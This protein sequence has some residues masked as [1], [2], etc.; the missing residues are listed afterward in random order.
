[1]SRAAP[2][3]LNR[4]TKLIQEP[5]EFRDAVTGIELKVLFL[6]KQAKLSRVEQI[7]TQSWALDFG[8]AHTATRTQ[9]IVCHGWASICLATGSG[10]AIWNGQ[11]AGP[12]TLALLPPGQTLDGSTTGTFDWLSVAIPPELWWRS[13]HAAGLP[14][15]APTKLTVCH[16]PPAQELRVRHMMADLK[17]AVKRISNDDMPQTPV[18]W[19]IE[20][21]ITELFILANELA[22]GARPYS[23]ALLNRARLAR[24]AEEWM[25]A[26]MAEPVSITDACLALR[27]SRRELEY[28]FRGIFDQSPRDYFETLRLHEIR[29]RLSQPDL[30]KRTVTDVAL[31]H[32][33]LH[34]GRFA[35]RYRARFGENPTD[36]LRRNARS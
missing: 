1:M 13:V 16:L 22:K 28:A 30:A 27:V 9:G 24:A 29:R 33:I 26:S 2:H 14:E 10:S 35:A 4:S 8:V 34:L 19:H 18:A 36:T 32:G 31:E 25:M 5:D 6:K 20:S 7:Q 3:F 17:Q 12:G 11:S 23:T 15:D 21:M